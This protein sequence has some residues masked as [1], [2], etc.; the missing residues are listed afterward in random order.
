ME[1]TEGAGVSDQPIVDLIALDDALRELV[2]IDE[3]QSRVVEL[4]FFSGLREEVA[5]IV[6]VS[7]VTVKRDWRI[8]KAFLLSRIEGGLPE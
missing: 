4:R 1:L 7:Q 2:S 3:R 6:G 8:A 5:G